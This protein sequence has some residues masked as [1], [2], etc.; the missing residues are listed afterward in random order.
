M[1]ISGRR[2]EREDLVLNGD[3]FDG[4]C[5]YFCVYRGIENIYPLES[6]IYI[7]MYYNVI[8]GGK[9]GDY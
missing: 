2:E 5:I 8:H 6:Y 1:R 3:F 9:R 4:E 7:Y